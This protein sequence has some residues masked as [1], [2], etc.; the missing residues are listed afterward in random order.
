[1][2]DI[3]WYLSKKVKFDQFKEKQTKLLRILK[4]FYPS[5][6]KYDL[7]WRYLWVWL[8]SDDVTLIWFI[9]NLQSFKIITRKSACC[10]DVKTEP[11]DYSWQVFCFYTYVTVKM[12]KYSDKMCWLGKHGRP[13]LLEVHFQKTK[14]KK[15]KPKNPQNAQRL[16]ALLPPVTQ[17]FVT[18]TNMPL[19]K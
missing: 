7:S 13:W 17:I 1:M 15:R 4:T 5:N 12:F 19:E 9:E 3:I 14:T 6:P 18:T 2:S 16:G 8:L 10:H 11:K